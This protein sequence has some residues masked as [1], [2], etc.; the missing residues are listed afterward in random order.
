MGTGR[1]VVGK[2]FTPFA[3]EPRQRA[4]DLEDIAADVFAVRPP[5]VSCSTRSR[6]HR[7]SRSLAAR[8]R[9][10]ASRQIFSEVCNASDA[11][12][13]DRRVPASTPAMPDDRKTTSPGVVPS[14]FTFL[15]ANVRGFTSKTAD[16]T[17]MIERAEYPTYVAFTE[18]F[19][20]RAKPASLAG[21]ELVSRLDRRTGE[22]QG[23]IILFAKKGFEKNIVHVGDS[24]VHERSWHIVHSERGPILIGLQYRRPNKGERASIDSLYEE[25]QQFSDQAIYTVLIGDF[26]VHEASWLRFS[27]GTSAEGRALQAFA[28]ITGLEEKVGAPTRGDYLLDLV[29]SD[30][31]R[32]LKC[33]VIVG[34]SDHK[35]VLGV[36]NFG[37]PE[38]HEVERELFDYKGA[39]WDDLR[40]EFSD[41]DW[42]SLFDGLSCDDAAMK[43][44]Q[45]IMEGV[46]K[47]VRC[48]K[49]RVKVSSHPWLNDKCGVAIEAKLA[50][51]GIETEISEQDRCSIV[52]R[53][54]FDA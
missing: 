11:P 36:V 5:Q 35:A 25:I 15:H 7:G 14:S 30:L 50:A 45:V 37:I 8:E 47:H 27:D 1:T 44:E 51:N 21:Y 38:V 43:F 54:E 19:L 52:L 23:G 40:T 49:T 26:N 10:V 20:D 42:Q 24:A 28:N 33:S 48:R 4:I 6:T 9:R 3:Q 12:V 46:R 22:K 32:E 18:T 13:D 16:L 29:L 34:E 41:Y 2:R 17:F 31:G 39:S 53:R